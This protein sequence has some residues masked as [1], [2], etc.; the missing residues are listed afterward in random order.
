MDASGGGSSHLAIARRLLAEHKADEA[1][2]HV[3]RH[4]LEAPEEADA[5]RVLF[6]GY[7][8]LGRPDDAALAGRRLLDTAPTDFEVRLDTARLELRLGRPHQV[9]GLLAEHAGEDRAAAAL[10]AEAYERVG[11]T[12]LAAS[13]REAIPGGEWAGEVGSGQDFK[14]LYFARQLCGLL[15]E[16]AVRSTLREKLISCLEEGR[17]A[18]AGPLLRKWAAE[19]SPELRALAL[20]DWC[21]LTGD[22]DG[23]RRALER[24][25]APSD[26]AGARENRLGDLAQSIGDFEKARRHYRR[27]TVL[28]PTD[29][30]AWLDL[31]RTEFLRGDRNA[32]VEACQRVV[33]AECEVP[34]EDDWMAREFLQELQSESSEGE[35]TRGLYGLVW[36]ERGGGLLEVE[37]V[38]R[39]GSKGLLLTGNVG[40][41]LEDATRVAF[42]FLRSEYGCFTTG[43]VHV[44]FPEFRAPK[45]GGSAGLLLA[46]QMFTVARDIEPARRLAVTGEV[47]LGGE[48]R[49]IGGLREKVTAAHLHGADR[50]ILPAENTSDLVR[51]PLAAKR[52]L[53]FT[54][55]R[56]FDETLSDLGWNV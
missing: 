49:A 53:E 4:L 48:I 7:Q 46:L 21:L 32:A 45:D 34:E 1:V 40:R 23:A 10:L 36:W 18:E 13:L 20:T 33:E 2:H 31:A 28:E 43:G 15:R 38:G 50:V 37:V 16:H 27:A 39:S 6:K 25:D 12:M 42:E 35:L 47:T 9:I 41:A 30:N 52:S 24:N 5:L 17:Y 19:T 44:H 55:V 3:K 26:L 29:T 11:K 51:I 8:Q 22:R 56:T 14:R 54:R